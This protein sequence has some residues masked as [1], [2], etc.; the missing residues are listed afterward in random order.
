VSIQI[1]C[2]LLNSKKE[3]IRNINIEY[4]NILYIIIYNN[5]IENGD[6]L[7]IIFFIDK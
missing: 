4:N 6:Q 7:A 1:F 5:N 3:N 2:R